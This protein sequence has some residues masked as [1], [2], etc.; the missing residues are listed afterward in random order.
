MEPQE[1]LERRL[2]S[3]WP[4]A[5]ALVPVAAAWLR[6]RLA[7]AAPDWTDLVAALLILGLVIL[8]Q[9]QRRRLEGISI[10][11]RLTGVFNSRYL[12]VELDRQV[13][14]A[15]RTQLPLSMIFIDVDDLKKVNDR[16]GHLAGDAVLRRVSAALTTRIR[17][18]MDLCFRYGGDE[19]LVLC[20]HAGLAMAGA[21]AERILGIRDALGD[22]GVT[23]SLG[24]IELR[25]G[26]T[27]R[28][29][30]KR[31]DGVMYSVKRRGKNAVG[32]D[33]A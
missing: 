11:D 14:V 28:D 15:H 22:R 17:E 24:V 1:P 29:F 6:G 2:M 4:Y 13:H 12:R 31:A 30:L 25:E 18:H 21:I 26:E 20:P 33:G 10:T 23:L 16:H 19:F 7:G 32:F 8:D 5:I 27:P 3:N 9:R